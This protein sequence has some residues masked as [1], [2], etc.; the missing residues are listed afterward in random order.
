M[1]AYHGY[2]GAPYNFVG[3]NR[4]V[5]RK[6]QNQLQPHNVIDTSLKS[7]RIV[8]EIEAVTPIFVSDGKKDDNKAEEFY[9]NC[10]GR[11][12]IPGSTV[13]G[14]VQSNVQILS[15]SSVAGDIQ[16]GTLMYRNVANG[17]EQKAYNSILG[18]KTIQVRGK[19]G[20]S[21]TLSVLKNVKAGYI[22]RKGGR[23]A[24]LPSVVDQISRE[25][26]EMNYYVVSER[27]IMEGGYKGFEELKSMHLQHLNKPLDRVTGSPFRKDTRG[28]RVHYIGTPDGEYRPYVCQVYYLLK[29]EKQV[30]EV[31]PVKEGGKSYEGKG[32]KKGYLLSSGYIREKKVIYVIPQ[33]DEKGECIP[34]SPGDIDSYQRDYEGKKNQI[35]ARNLP[36]Y[37]LPQEGEVKPVFYIRLGGRLYFGFTPRLRLFY[38]KTIFEGLSDEQKKEGVD[39]SRSLFGYSSERESYK[40]R[41]SFMDAE[42]KQEK[43]KTTEDAFL[44]LGGPKPTSYLDYLKGEKGKAVSYNQDFELRGVKQYWLKD[45]VQQGAVG[46]NEKVAARFRPFDKG[47]IFKGEIRFNN[48]TKEELGMVLWGLLL[49][50]D[51]NQNIGKGKPYGYGRMKVRLIQLKILDT[52]ALYKSHSLCMEPYQDET[53]QKDTYISGIKEEL[54]RMLGRD[55]M[56]DPRITDFL[57][58]KD[59]RKVPPEGRTRYMELSEYQSRVTNQIC[60]PPVADVVEG[61]EILV[62]ESGK[63]GSGGGWGNNKNQGMRNIQQTHKS[64]K[65]GKKAGADGRSGDYSSGGNASTCMGNLLKGLDLK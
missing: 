1:E 27:K 24:I 2:V 25:Q 44:V 62:T 56:R 43:W 38:E 7:G 18:N 53:S 39:Y 15:G 42:L 60:L 61:K 22:T 32:F 46:K 64:Q 47:A 16:D 63:R 40:S 3:I 6:E 23:Y 50:K 35:G 54:S 58:M 13:R 21:N 5:N 36:F 59:I 14:L 19:D 57:L 49:E 28:V 33:I 11:Y 29:G 10:Y 37:S 52:D 48:L 31:H 41:L 26:G 51:S 20:R 8:Y 30:V 55:I 45:H 65:E 4:N 34:I 9:K 17:R 12:A